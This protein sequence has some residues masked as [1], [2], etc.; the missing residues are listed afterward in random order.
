M[1]HATPGIEAHFQYGKRLHGAGRL[2]EAAQIYQQIL[3][4]MPEHAEAMDAL[5]ALLLQAGEAAQGLAWIERA[6][7][8]KGRA[9]VFH[10]HRAHALLVLRRPVEAAEAARAAL[11]LKRGHAEA[12][13]ALGHAL[14]DSGDWD[15]AL[16]A[17]REAARLK[18]DLP[19]ALNNLG[20]ALHH[21][22]R[23]DEAARALNRA[24]V[25]DPNDPGALI[26][27]SGVLK[28]LGR[29]EE[30]GARLD[31]ALKRAPGDVRALYDRAL[32]WLL[33]GRLAEAWPG[34]EERFRA[35]AVPDRALTTPGVPSK[36]RWP[37]KPRWRGEPLAGRTLLVHAE[38]GL[39]DTIQFCRYLSSPGAPLGGRAPLDGPRAPLGGPGAPLDGIAASLNG[40]VILE[41]QP[42]IARL[43]GTLAGPRRIVA[44]G[45]P[46]PDHDLTCPLMSLPAIHA[47][48]L[49]TIPAPIPYLS[50]G[51]ERVARWRARI[52]EHGFRVGVAWQGN[53]DRREDHGRS[54]TPDHFMPLA[55]L[56]G[57]R[58]ISLQKDTGAL[59]SGPLASGSPIE[60]PGMKNV[61][62]ERPG[63]ERP[64][65]ESLGIESLGEDFDSGPDGFLDTAAA[66]MSLDLVISSDTVIPHLAG[67]LGRPVWLAL[68]KVPD[69]R[70][71]TEGAACP[72]YPTMRLF[73]Q[74]TRDDWTPVF[75]A[76]RARLAA[77]DV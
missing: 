3:A 50:A 6:I 56:P 24:L 39:G 9:P 15:G 13:Q 30:A 46:L 40:T 70:W 72:W 60:R 58:L 7:G 18:P 41:A 59:A 5:G 66:M 27:L 36:P 51:P 77:R 14:S 55:A 21:R 65:I 38:Q 23:L 26:N 44:A 4:A 52:G 2:N 17:Y 64:G 67:A 19:D 75:A 54:L 28:E 63:T 29:F 76:M 42:R 16:Q 61:G 37:N 43:L 48:T 69:W 49:S 73:R 10:T 34:W 22:H 8:L 31:A 35:G 11:R 33:Q 74:D 68:R 45:E 12:Y 71:L 32:L 62:I 25:H 20:A 1:S 53:P 57:V 47:T